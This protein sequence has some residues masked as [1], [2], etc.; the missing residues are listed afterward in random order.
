MLKQ[1][2]IRLTALLMAALLIVPTVVGCGSKE[3]PEDEYSVYSELVVVSKDKDSTVSQSGEEGQS[4]PQATTTTTQGKNNSG[5]KTTTAAK[6]PSNN[7]AF[8]GTAEQALAAMPKEL[9]NT[10]LT[11][12]YWWDP[13][14][15]TEKTAI[16][17]FTAKTGI[18]V[19]AD[20][21]SYSERMTELAARITAGNSPDIVR[22]L[23]NAMYQLMSLQPITN[24][25]YDFSDDIWWK[26][27][28][29]D[30]TFNGSIYATNVR[31]KNTVML[32][33]FMIYYNKRALRQTDLEDPY[34]LWKKDHSKWTWAKLWSMCET[35]KQQHAKESDY[36]GIAMAY[37]NSYVRMFGCANYD[38]NPKTGKWENYVDSPELAKRWSE[39]MTYDSKGLSKISHGGKTSFHRG[40]YLFY[41]N[42]PYACRVGDP[43]DDVMKEAGILGVVPL[44]SDTPY[45][46]LYEYTGFGIA[47]GAKNAAAVPYYLR[48]VYDDS[49]YD[50]SKVYINEEAKTVCEY[51]ND[52]AET[53]A[54]FGENENYDM[55]SKII[56]G[57]PDQVKSTLTSYK[58]VIQAI[59][60]ESNA[61]IKSLSK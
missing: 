53:K 31:P 41:A 47:Q 27:Q 13:Y 26:K 21:C 5:K 25:G 23:T 37:N 6:K 36:A 34:T 8:K 45:Q 24:S 57:T 29:Q 20:V 11:Y 10:T 2:G 28:M 58:G 39:Y 48:Y 60:D 30:F 61:Q 40:N 46:L 52:L 1:K 9:R 19:K 15:M 51:T 17:K 43:T 14:E 16:Q 18:K 44:P 49:S 3:D 32:D 42:G 59:V 12:F 7:G 38:Y 54:F 56:N 55:F 50:L 33:T 22:V 4:D 35:F